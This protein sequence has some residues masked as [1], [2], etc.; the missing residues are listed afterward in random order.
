IYEKLFEYLSKEIQVE[1]IIENKTSVTLILS[2]EGTKEIAGDKMFKSGIEI[3]K[4]IRF[5]YKKEKIHIILDTIKLEK[6][7][8]YTMVDFLQQLVDHR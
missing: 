2:L 8:L 6:H 1:K 5:A 7:W 3:S 4:Y